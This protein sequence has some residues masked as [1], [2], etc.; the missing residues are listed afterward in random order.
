MVLMRGLLHKFLVGK[1]CCDFHVS[2]R[3]NDA[4]AAESHTQV[5]MEEFFESFQVPWSSSFLQD[6]SPDF[7]RRAPIG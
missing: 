1:M 6:I 7:T 3:K 2:P 4:G 5:R